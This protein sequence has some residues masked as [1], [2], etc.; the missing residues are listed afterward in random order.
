LF[1]IKVSSSGG[2]KGWQCTRAA[3]DFSRGFV[4][5]DRVPGAG[6]ENGGS[7]AVGAGADY[8]GARFDDRGQPWLL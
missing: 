5:R 2:R 1:A 3:A 7:Q 4:D 8:Y 6:Q